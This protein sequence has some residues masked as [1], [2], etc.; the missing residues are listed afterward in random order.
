MPQAS[1]EDINLLSSYVDQILAA[2]K[3]N[4]SADTSDLERKIDCLV[5]ELYGLTNGEVKIID[6]EAVV[7]GADGDLF[8]A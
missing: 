5:Y 4:P 8:R 6:P 1:D 7:S 2:K 3:A